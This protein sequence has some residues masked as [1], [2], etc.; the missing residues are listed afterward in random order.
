[1]RLYMDEVKFC[2]NCGIQL[3][4][5]EKFCA[6]CGIDITDNFEKVKIAKNDE[7]KRFKI[8]LGKHGKL[9]VFG[10]L[11]I[12]LVV[13]GVGSNWYNTKEHQVQR[14]E[15]SIAHGYTK[16]MRNNLIDLSGKKLS[17]SDLKALAELVKHDKNAKKSIHKQL[18]SKKGEIFN[19]REKGKIM[20]FFPRYQA[21]VTSMCITVETDAAYPLMYVDGKKVVAEDDYYGDYEINRIMPGIHK[22]KIKGLFSRY[23]DQESKLTVTPDMKYIIE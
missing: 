3:I 18:T 13:F 2:P 8:N 7:K 12:L 1:M 17:N 10:T 23:S 22:L 6:E 4:D 9:K 15:S 5:V 19:L 21:E 20:G 14:I 16:Q 11:V